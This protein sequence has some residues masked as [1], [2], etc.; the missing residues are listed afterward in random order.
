MVDPPDLFLAPQ[1]QTP[2][3]DRP[4]LRPNVP[5]GMGPDVVAALLALLFAIRLHLFQPGLKSGPTPSFE[6]CRREFRMAA[7]AIV[8]RCLRQAADRTFRVREL[9]PP[10]SCSQRAR[11]MKRQ[12]AHHPTM[13]RSEE[14]RVGKECRSRW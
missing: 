12:S 4:R 8:V 9:L 5:L 14:R 10:S 3:A 6:V 1:F 11:A 13:T 2:V 7:A